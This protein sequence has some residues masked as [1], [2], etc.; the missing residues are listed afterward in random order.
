L[1]L[2]LTIDAEPYY[3]NLLG[4]MTLLHIYILFNIIYGDSRTV[5]L[6]VDPAFAYEIKMKLC[7][8]GLF[9]SDYTPSIITSNHQTWADT[10]EINEKQFNAE[11]QL[12]FMWDL[13]EEK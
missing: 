6:D 9:E 13:W 2:I 3:Q 5:R 11:L 4:T 1:L 12:N 8:D 7:V 10:L